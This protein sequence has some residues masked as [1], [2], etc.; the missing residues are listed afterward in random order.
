MTASP[1]PWLEED[2]LLP[3]PSWRLFSDC[4]FQPRTE[5]SQSA[6]HP[7]RGIGLARAD[8]NG[9]PESN[10]RQQIPE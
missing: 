3:A 7:T 4:F 1:M 5:S 6:Y 9:L 10:L 2:K 8:D